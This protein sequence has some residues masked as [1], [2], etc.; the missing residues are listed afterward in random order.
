MYRTQFSV[1]ELRAI[2]ICVHICVVIFYMFYAS[3][4]YVQLCSL[5]IS[6]QYQD[7]DIICKTQPQL[8][9]HLCHRTFSVH[10]L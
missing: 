6:S 7:F 10:S 8:Y 5:Y 3:E 2:V 9:T 1:Q 4:K